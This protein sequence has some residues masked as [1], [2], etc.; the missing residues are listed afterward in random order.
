MRVTTAAR[1]GG[2][3][4]TRPRDSQCVLKDRFSIEWGRGTSARGS[5]D[6]GVLGRVGSL[7]AVPGDGDARLVQDM[8]NTATVAVHH[9]GGPGRLDGLAV[10][11]DLNVV[12]DNLTLGR[13]LV[14]GPLR[15]G[16]DG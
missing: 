1:K 14:A 4:P 3:A 12:E 13:V 16:G 10:K 5:C 8:G 15:L 11:L 9:I 7:G 2:T 6:A